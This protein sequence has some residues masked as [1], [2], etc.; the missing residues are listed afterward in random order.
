MICHQSVTR[1]GTTTVTFSRDGFT[2]VVQRVPAEVC[3]NCGEAY[4]DQATTEELLR[5]ARDLRQPRTAV[6]V[7]DYNTAAA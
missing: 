5:L 3:E 1:P 6:V 2:L 4:V 7:R